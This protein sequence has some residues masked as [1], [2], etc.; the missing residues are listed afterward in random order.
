ME[1]T[2]S[3]TAAFASEHTGTLLFYHPIFLS[4]DTGPHPEHKRRLRWILRL[5][6]QQKLIA[7][8]ALSIATPEPATQPQL[9]TAHT[10]RHITRIQQLAARGGGV[11]DSDTIVSA[12]SYQAALYAAG[13][14]ISAVKVLQK[15]KA[16]NAFALV[17][18]PGHHATRK[19]AMGFCLFNNVAVTANYLLN[20][21]QARR[22]VIIDFDAHHGNGTQDIF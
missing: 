6:D 8:H 9:L 12:K 17:R 22:I 5:L 3:N 14:G 18:P 13:A 7:P 21:K 4:H 15:K 20:T 10:Q 2:K 11:I 1:G 19:Q 16:H